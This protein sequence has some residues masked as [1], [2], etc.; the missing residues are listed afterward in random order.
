MGERGVVAADADGCHG[1][2]AFEVAVVDT[3]GAGDAFCAG[4]AVRLAEGVDL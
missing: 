4:L 2:P 1:V 3:T